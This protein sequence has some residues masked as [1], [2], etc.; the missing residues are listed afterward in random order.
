MLKQT[1]ILAITAA[2]LA[3]TIGAASAATPAAADAP[4][5]GGP[6]AEMSMG[7]HGG[8]HRM[9]QRMQQQ[10]NQ[11]HGQLKLN[12]DQEKLWQT[13]LDTMKQNRAAMRESRRQMHQQF[14]QM[15]QQ[16]ILDL[17]AMHAAHQ[18]IEQQNE[19]LREQT[20]AAWLNFYNSLNDQQKTTVSTA[21][22]KHFAK[23]H[24][25]GKKMHERWGK[26]HGAADAPAGA[27]AT[28]K[29]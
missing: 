25:R 4:P 11:L 12:A 18:K 20:S 9:E 13:A 17:N 6:G 14:E 10:L 5:P 27:S 16:P 24:E 3:M 26:Q 22:K 21:L 1:R 2:A 23:M 7:G 8:H 29:P 28:L 15:Q 19:Q